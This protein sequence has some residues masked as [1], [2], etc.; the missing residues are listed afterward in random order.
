MFLE[1]TK[2]EYGK[3]L[4]PSYYRW[5]SCSST[6][7]TRKK[8]LGEKL[9]YYPNS[10]SCFQLIRIAKSAVISLNPVPSINQ[11]TGLGKPTCQHCT[12]TIAKNHR[13]V[14]CGVC[15]FNFHMKCASISPKDYKTTMSWICSKCLQETLPVSLRVESEEALDQLALDASIIDSTDLLTFSPSLTAQARKQDNILEE[16]KRNFSELLLVHLNV[17]SIQNKIDEIKLL[18]KDLKA[19]IIFLSEMK[20]DSSYH[21]VQ[22]TIQG[23]IIYRKDR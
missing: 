18:N 12:K 22:F 6:R 5:L 4:A 17:N 19:Q 15:Q 8:F 3:L 1:G 7:S 21:D 11:N 13:A 16:G 10:D 9:N 2:I 23:Y 20:I 14:Q